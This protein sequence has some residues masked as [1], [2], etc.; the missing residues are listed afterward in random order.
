MT[1][2]CPIHEAAVSVD[3][4]AHDLNN[5]CTSMLGFAELTL[6]GLP[7]GSQELTY[8][9][10]ITESSRHAMALAERLRQIAAALRALNVPD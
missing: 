3:Q 6:D 2:S 8:L 4:V 5:A 1:P 10:E 9:Q 7:A